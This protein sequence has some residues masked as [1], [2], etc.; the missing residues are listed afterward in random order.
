MLCLSHSTHSVP[1]ETDQG[2]TVSLSNE[3]KEAV[4][5]GITLIFLCQFSMQKK[6][7]FISWSE[8]QKQHRFALTYH[9]L[10][11]RYI[12]RIDDAQTPHFFRSID[13][14]STYMAKK[15]LAM[16]NSYASAQKP[17]RMR[18]SLSKSELPGPMRLNAFF[19]S[20]WDL[21]TGWI[22]WMSNK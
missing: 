7:W 19:A 16:L 6:F 4:D 20:E 11:N 10:S 12:V 8:Q 17:Y 3:A 21:D 18:L 15:S 13:Q 22:E 1:V 2:F 5:N 14:A 9:T